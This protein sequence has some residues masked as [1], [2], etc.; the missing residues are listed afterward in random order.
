MNR[1]PVEKRA[2]KGVKKSDSAREPRAIAQPYFDGLAKKNLKGVPWADN[3]TL[4]APLNPNGGAEVPIVDKANILAFLNP[5]LPG[6]GKV[7][8]IRHFV[9]GNWVCTRADIGLAGIPS[10][11]VRVIDSFRI[12]KDRIAEQ[13]NHY[14]PRPALPPSTQG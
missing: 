3:A 1:T 7:A 4:R 10:A 13:E 9:E 12:E 14:D 5:P 2:K 8:L 11:K 6:L